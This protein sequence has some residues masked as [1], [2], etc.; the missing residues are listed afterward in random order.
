MTFL[1]DK[2][3]GLF[4]EWDKPDSPGCALAIIKG[5]EMVYKR[6]YGMADLER[7][8]PISP[9]SVFDLGSTG[10]QF[11]AML[12][13]ILAEQGFLSLDDNVHQYIPEMPAY[14]QPI[15]LRH[16]IHH[17]SGLR[18][19]TT[20]M[21][22]SGRPCE[23]FYYEDELLD[24]ICRQKELNFKPGE[25]YLYS[26]TGYF[27]LGV[28]A[29]RVTGKPF[30]ELLR[31]HL[32]EPLGMRATDL[33]DDARRIVKNRAIGYSPREG[34]G[35]CT[36]MSLCG[37][38]GDGAILS[39]VED[40][41]LWDQN[42]YNNKLGGGGQGLILKVHA[43]GEL[44]SGE[45]LDYAFGLFVSD[46]RG[47]RRV[48]HAGGW[49]GYRSELARFPDQ[50][51]SVICLTNL[52]SVSP[53]RL[54]QQ[55]A[56]LYLADQFTEQVPSP[57]VPAFSELAANQIERI[58]G[59]YRNRRTGSVLRLSTREGKLIGEVFGLS[60]PMV[61][62]SSTHLK[63][64]ESPFDLEVDLEE[65]QWENEQTISVM[66]DEGKPEP[67][68]KMTAI[69][70]TPLQL[71]EY[72]GNY[73]S[74]ELDISYQVLLE[75]EHLFLKRGYSPQEA[76]QPM[77]LDLFTGRD[78]EFEFERDEQNQICAFRL[79]AGRVRNIRFAKW[80]P[81]TNRVQPAH[82]EM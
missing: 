76:L 27:L 65:P 67:Y 78:A 38:Y 42:F 69:P 58:T 71:A 2:V 13:V 34:D 60:L 40:L 45:R 11:T 17:T 1:T 77:T 19:Y 73:H 55:V 32:L 47:L 26:N 25:E 8:V 50:E 9:A 43:P 81:S 7:N 75:G 57:G 52:G 66:L 44:N 70:I 18:D 36:D 51:F 64:V 53:S 31:E 16:L 29:K 59:L 79:G 23:N 15:T 20:L 21:E 48:A 74:D 30:P 61:A 3:D 5:G 46:Y 12:I 62:T 72:V 14:E 37:G 63:A 54:A 24:L 4:A 80:G 39:T 68:Q 56:D 33:N 22:M 49:A 28:I 35:Y 6:G 82:C 41:F 10:K